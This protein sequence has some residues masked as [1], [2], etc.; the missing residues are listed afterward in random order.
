MKVNIKRKKQSRE[1]FLIFR[2]RTLVHLK[3]TIVTI[4]FQ[5]RSKL[6]LVW[7]GVAH[8]YYHYVQTARLRNAASIVLIFKACKGN[9]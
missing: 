8:T 9:K 3:W 1:Y 2:L 5:G 7:N 6:D 4:D